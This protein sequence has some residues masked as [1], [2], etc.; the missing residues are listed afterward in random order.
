[1]EKFMEFEDLKGNTVGIRCSHVSSIKANNK[2]G[3]GGVCLTVGG[4]DITVRG[5]YERVVRLLDFDGPNEIRNNVNGI[6]AHEIAE[7]LVPHIKRGLV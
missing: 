3:Y 7:K 2:F 6:S 4:K 5:T 1:M